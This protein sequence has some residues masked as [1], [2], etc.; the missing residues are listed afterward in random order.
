MRLQAARS[1]SLCRNAE[2]CRD[3]WA[4]LRKHAEPAQRRRVN[5]PAPGLLTHPAWCWPQE[6]CRCLHLCGDGV[7]ACVSPSTAWRP[8]PLAQRPAASAREL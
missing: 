2:R 8:R 3:S 6:L 1:A 4:G 5:A 7:V